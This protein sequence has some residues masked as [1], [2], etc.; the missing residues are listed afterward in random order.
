M[1]QQHGDVCYERRAKRQRAKLG[2]RMA[3][4]MR[5]YDKC[6][7]ARGH[8]EPVESCGRGYQSKGEDP[9]RDVGLLQGTDS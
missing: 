5:M 8:C 6:E 4:D 3:R 2:V 1:S 9:V 7:A